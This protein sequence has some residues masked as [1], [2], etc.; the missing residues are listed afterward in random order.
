MQLQRDFC[1][2][3]M[4]KTGKGRYLPERAE[5]RKAFA[6]VWVCLKRRFSAHGGQKIG[7]VLKD[8]SL[9]PA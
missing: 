9:P 6:A 5:K 3:S 4:L 1:D 7:S 8:H 2:N